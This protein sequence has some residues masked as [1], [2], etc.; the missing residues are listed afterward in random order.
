MTAEGLGGK[1]ARKGSVL[2]NLA[3][4]EAREADLGRG[5]I[6]RPDHYREGP[7]PVPQGAVELGWPF[8]VVLMEMTGPGLYPLP[9]RIQTN[10]WMWVTMKRVRPKV[11]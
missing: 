2:E 5:T 9:G 11:M 3:C 6:E 8:T 10:H 1:G 4:E 7:L